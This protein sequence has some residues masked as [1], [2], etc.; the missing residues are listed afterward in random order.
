[1]SVVHIVGVDPGLVHTGVVGLTF[2]TR[3]KTLKITSTAIDGPDAAAVA[4]W[5]DGKWPLHPKVFVEAYTPRQNLSTDLRMELAQ[6]D[7]RAALRGA[8][9]LPNMG[10]K[11]VISRD[12]M[13][14]VEVWNFPTSTHHQDLRSAARIALLGMVKDA[15]M[16][17]ELAT[18]VRD[19]L[20]LRPWSIVHE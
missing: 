15:E 12:L 16:N 11:R 20:D 1:M 4:K 7:L 13:E 10:V 8:K 9:F 18:M 3:T 14:V 5:I 19:H 17:K 6:H 2:G